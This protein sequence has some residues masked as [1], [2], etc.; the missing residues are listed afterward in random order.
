MKKNERISD[1]V[2][3]LGVGG[4]EGLHECYLGYFQCFNRAEYYEAHDVLEHLWLQQKDENYAFFKGLIQMA[5]AFVHL[6]KHYQHPTH[7]KHSR[8]LRPAVRLFL[9][10]LQNIEPYGRTHLRLDVAAA[11]A[12]CRA[13]IA[14]IEAG[15]YEHNPWRPDRA[16]SLKLGR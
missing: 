12:L 10:A 1:F 4:A 11:S 3:R 2:A 16:P 7:P 5:G 15:G 6:Q 9:L 14:Q 13:W 8:R